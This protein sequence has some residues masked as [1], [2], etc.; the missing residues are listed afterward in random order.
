LAKR[1][2]RRKNREVIRAGELEIAKRDIS[3]LVAHDAGVMKYVES[4]IAMPIREPDE[5]Q[6]TGAFG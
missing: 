6:I 5:P 4:T 2:G 1:C 3:G